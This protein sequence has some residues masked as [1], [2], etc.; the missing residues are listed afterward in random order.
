MIGDE[1]VF[2]DV[3]V[4]GVSPR[5]LPRIAKKNAFYQIILLLLILLTGK[6]R[7]LSLYYLSFYLAIRKVVDKGMRNVAIFVCYNDQP[8]DV[9][10][11]L[12]ALHIRSNCRTIVIQ[13]GLILSPA[14]YFPSIAKEFWAWGDLSRK[15]Y[16]SRN[17]DG[18][19]MLTGRYLEDAGDKK[20]DFVPINIDGTNKRINF[21][22]AFSFSHNELKNAILFLRS[23]SPELLN[24][25]GKIKFSYKL[26]PSTKFKRKLQCWIAINAPWMR[27]EVDSME[28]LSEKYDGLITLNS[29]SAVDFLLKGK[30]VF[31]MKFRED[32]EFPSQKYGFSV[33]KIEQIFL[34]RIFVMDEK[35]RE[36]LLFLKAALNI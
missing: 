9:A 13:H 24:S 8:Y 28:A 35:N 34:D 7:Y 14:F 16:S 25:D 36:R 5:Y 23:L 32:G 22:L 30:P 11:L 26:H 31:F 27:E 15:Y 4:N 33:T 6:K 12:V 20:N 19:F 1:E 2:F 18:K 29:T 21:L 3:A 10:A 17:R